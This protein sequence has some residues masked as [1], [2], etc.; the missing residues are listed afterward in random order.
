VKY[1]I[2]ESD[3]YVRWFRKL[4]S[5]KVL[6]NKIIVRLYRIQH[7]GYFGDYKFIDKGVY[8]LRFKIS[9]GIRIYY[10]VENNKVV[11]LLGGG[12]KSTQKKDID[13]AI[14]LNDVIRS[15]KNEI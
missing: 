6:T 13:K 15:K 12:N 1:S 8:E 9:S 2:V 7:S 11:L 4:K 14:K 10:T 5:N 3:T